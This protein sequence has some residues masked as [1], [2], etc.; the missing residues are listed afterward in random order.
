M[1][2]TSKAAQRAIRSETVA[3]RN[4]QRGAALIISLILMLA[5]TVLG[6][7]GMN[8]A[9]LEL[10]MAGN[11]QAQQTAFQ[12][13]ETGIDR[14]II[15]HDSPG[16]LD[17][18]TVDADTDGTNEI[19]A[20]TTYIGESLVPDGDGWSLDIAA[21]HFDTVSTGTGARGAASTHNQSYYIIGP[22][23]SSL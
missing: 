15:E 11:M 19:D 6:I 5:L 20:R 17:P 23:L 3:R 2:E 16:S 18:I 7:S 8:M 12:R 14:A 10:T 22:S 21:H 9:T 4:E 1:A 13:A